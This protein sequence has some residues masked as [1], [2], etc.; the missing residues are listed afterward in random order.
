MS[1]LIYLDNA[2]TTAPAQEVITAMTSSLRE[3]YFN[4]S[5]LYASGFAVRKQIEASRLMIRQMLRA[6]D[7]VFTSGGTEASNLA[8]LGSLQ[9]VR[10]PGRVLYSAVE[11]SA[12][13][14]TCES[15]SGQHEVLKV[16]VTEEGL[17]DLEALRPLLTPETLMICVMQVNNEV[18][19]IQ[20]LQEVI[21]LRNSLCPDALL[22]VDGVQGF[23]HLPLAM[24]DGV[25]SY[26]LSGHKIHGPKGIGAL[27][28]GK[29]MR[30]KPMIFGGSQEN[31]LRSGTE[32]TP[33]IIGLTAAIE[34][35]PKENTIRERKLA[36]Y[37]LVKELIPDAM[38]NGPQPESPS[39]CEHI[40]NLSFP[41]VRA[42]T[43][44]HA[45]EGEGVMVSQG[46]ACSSKKK[47][48]SATL[49][50]MNIA[51]AR[52]ESAL[53]FSF[54]RYTSFEDVQFAAHALVKA[55][56]TLRPYTHR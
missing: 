4:P 38:V 20:P 42:Q 13:A 28:L 22:H 30:V 25:D 31:S 14:K 34:A 47:T 56:Q 10:K 11:H 26:S 45:L 18:G 55:Y 7:L 41:P 37:H 24:T 54:S 9:N 19:A 40:I 2:A 3:S 33:G 15:L 16:P 27:A 53:R 48:P 51:K 5:S 17:I 6:E 36:F 23:L 44:M 29:R 12:V 35:Y 43:L 39:A 49:S 46:S 32:N 50:A 52:M 8:I 21:S 1:K